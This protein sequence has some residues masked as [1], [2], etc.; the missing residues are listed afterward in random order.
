M[1]ELYAGGSFFCSENLKE[2]FA[3]FVGEGFQT[4]SCPCG[5]QALSFIHLEKLLDSTSF[6]QTL[7]IRQGTIFDRKEVKL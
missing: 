3:L 4:K 6:L 7:I 5:C 2:Y 1:Y